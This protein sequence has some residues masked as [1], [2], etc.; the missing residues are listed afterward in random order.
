M[1]S[2][3]GNAD[4]TWDELGRGD[5]ALAA[6][7]A[8]RWLGGWLRLPDL[9]ADLVDCRLGVHRLAEHVIS[10]ARFVANSKIGLRWTYSGIGTPFFRASDGRD[11][12]VRLEG[13]DLVIDE[14]TMERRSAIT[15][16]SEAAAFV[17]VALGTEKLYPPATEPDEDAPAALTAEGAAFLSDWFG[18][19]TSVLEQLRAEADEDEQPSRL[20]LWPEHLDISFEQGDEAAKRRAGYG[21]SPGDA[22][23]AEPYF[24]VLPWTAVPDEG[25][26]GELHFHGARLG[27]A[28]LA[29]AGDQRAMA[30][31]FLRE[32]RDLLRKRGTQA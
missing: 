4:T 32:G 26:W 18:F 16:L 19:S 2:P 13:T 17:G 3:V 14:V 6:W 9:P 8:D 15:T 7:C 25:Y 5:A 27:W 28:D 21:S 23:H 20:Q 12:Q 1:V 24:Y 29:A 10:P 30:L 22:G 11:R 31:D